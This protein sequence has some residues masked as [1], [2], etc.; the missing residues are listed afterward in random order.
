[1][2]PHAVDL[3]ECTMK[4]AQN[5]VAGKLYRKFQFVDNRSTTS[6][7]KYAAM[8]KFTKKPRALPVVARKR[9]IPKHKS[10]ARN[11]LWQNSGAKESGHG[12][13]ICII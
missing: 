11:V 8:E 4:V 7:S 6:V 2:A 9:T 3:L 10:V 5:V 1:M 13:V 12:E